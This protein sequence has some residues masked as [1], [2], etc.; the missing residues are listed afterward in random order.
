MLLSKYEH[1]NRNNYVHTV[2]QD[3][4]NKVTDVFYIVQWLSSYSVTTTKMAKVP[5]APW[6][7]S[8]GQRWMDEKWRECNKCFCLHLCTWDKVSFFKYISVHWKLLQKSLDCLKL[9]RINKPYLIF[10]LCLN[11]YTNQRNINFSAF[12]D[13]IKSMIFSCQ[14]LFW[15]NY[16]LFKLGK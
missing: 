2:I 10:L 8:V 1:I 5:A 4:G 9:K 14:A 15:V 12:W 3:T 13:G 7:R 16:L 11:V 6:A